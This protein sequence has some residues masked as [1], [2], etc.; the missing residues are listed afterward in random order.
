[1]SPL[2]GCSAD[3]P[4]GV[5]SNSSMPAGRATTLEETIRL[6]SPLFEGSQYRMLE[7]GGA[8]ESVL[9]EDLAQRPDGAD[10]EP[11]ARAVFGHITDSHIIDATNPGRL[12]FLW[13]YSDFDEGY[14]TSGRFRPQDALTLHVLDATVRAFN[15]LE[16]GP[17]TRRGIDALMLTGDI[18]N[19]FLTSE[20][21]AAAAILKGGD[22]NSNP[23]GRYEGIQDHE[24]APRRLQLN[25]WHPE[26]EKGD[27]PRDQ[28]KEQHGYPTVPGLLAASSRTIEAPGTAFPW[29]VGFGNHDEA[30]RLDGSRISNGEQ[31]L[32]GLRTGPRLP[33]ELPEQMTTSRFWR[34]VSDGEKDRESLIAELPSRTITAS[35]LR[36][37]FDKPKFQAELTPPRQS[38]DRPG[39]PAALHY[40]F[41]VSPDVRGIMLNTS[42]PDGGGRAVLDQDQAAWLVEQLQA[43][44]SRYTDNEGRDVTAEVD[45]KLVVLFSHHPLRAFDEDPSAEDDG[46]RSITRGD[47]L[48]LL[49]RF[50]NL[51]LWMNGHEH[52]H[53]IVPHPGSGGSGGFWEVTTASLIDFPQQSRV[54]EM[55]DNRDGT[56]SIIATLV[57]HSSAGDVRRDGPQTPQS[58]AALSLELA[59]NRPGLDAGGVIGSSKDRNVEL[60]LTAPF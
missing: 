9:R 23:V 51:V 49:T 40:A 59:T 19:S 1:M 58:L 6:G 52:R 12:S 27:A 50:P 8:Q 5:A 15:D 2:S 7:K 14:P 53:K 31:F 22:G 11:A 34:Q 42:S 56:L 29:Y 3:T 45:D 55:L 32:D 10:A 28:W 47:L 57:D 4:R 17:V 54:V 16:R 26:P 24:P 60:L 37:V 36:S 33:L 38:V 39:S 25:V 20:V 48:D 44:S 41:D 13:Q 30:G 46:G 18:T 43:V 21:E 35:R